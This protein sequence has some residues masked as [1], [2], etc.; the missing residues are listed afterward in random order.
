MVTP[1]SVPGPADLVARHVVHRYGHV[2]ALHGVDLHV[3]AGSS[4]ALV[5]ESGSGKTTL[6]RCFNRMVDP[7]EG[8][9]TIGGVDLRTERVETLRRRIGYV[10]QEGGLLP[11]WSVLRNVELVPRL[12]GERVSA[13]SAAT[14]ALELVGLPAADYA[15][16][17][18][19]ELSGGQRQ[20]VALA[21]AL[22]AT[23]RVILLDEP[24]GA[25]DAISRADLHATFASARAATG[26][27]T[28]LVT[29]DLAEAARLC[30]RVVVMRAGRVEQAG[31][32]ADLRSAPATPYVADLL[33]RAIAGLERLR[34]DEVNA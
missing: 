14:A 3:A 29:H 1:L 18:P 27:T 16:R 33:R 5:G 21:R 31:S 12:S 13:T 19:H 9:V 28:L 17:F 32:F 23:P 11:H 22:A 30:D 2:T 24:F 8:R 10:P 4:V 20:R 6:L 25:L 34:G 26:V 15:A 7:V